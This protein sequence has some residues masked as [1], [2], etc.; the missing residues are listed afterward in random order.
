M[1]RDCS[2]YFFRLFYCGIYYSIGR[3]LIG[4]ILV[5]FMFYKIFGNVYKNVNE[6]INLKKLNLFKY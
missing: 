5:L 6:G 3:M 4:L 1:V 2:I